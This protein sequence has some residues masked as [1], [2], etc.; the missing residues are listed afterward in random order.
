MGKRGIY[1]V[2]IEDIEKQLKENAKMS[3]VK[4]IV[5]KNTAKMELEAKRNATFK[6]HYQGK[7]WVP[8]TGHTRRSIISNFLEG[9]LTGRV[10]PDV[11]YAFYLEYGTRYMASQ[12]FMGP[13][14]RKV[15][16]QFTADLD[17][18]VK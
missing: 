2:G 11:D 15:K 14:F 1:F 4:N 16:Q 12:P 6:G 3:D 7:K 13:A 9:G 17:R 10:T 8:A 18:L 5:K